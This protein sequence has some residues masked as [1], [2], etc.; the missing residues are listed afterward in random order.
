MEEVINEQ[1][2]RQPY[3]QLHKGRRRPIR[4][5]QQAIVSPG[6]QCKTKA[7]DRTID[8]PGL[9]KQLT[10]YLILRSV[11]NHPK[12]DIIHRFI[13]LRVQY[14]TLKVSKIFRDLA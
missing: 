6:E 13:P 3:G 8:D 14:K 7:E 11:T 4:Q 1:H 12:R 5:Q 10:C 9:Y 2:H